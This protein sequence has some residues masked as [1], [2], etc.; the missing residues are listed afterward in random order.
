MN[1]LS[2]TQDFSNSSPIP[3]SKNELR[4]AQSPTF[5]KTFLLWLE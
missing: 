4:N 5:K 2:D 1:I 3:N